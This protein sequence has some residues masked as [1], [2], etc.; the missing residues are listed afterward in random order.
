MCGSDPRRVRVLVVDDDD[1]ARLALRRMLEAAG[2]EVRE[3]ANGRIAMSVCRSDPP[4]VV[5][6]DIFMPEQEGIETIQSLRREF[7]GIKLIAI[8]GQPSASV[9]LRM[10]KL[11]GAQASLQKPVDMDTLV[12]TVRSVLE[13]PEPA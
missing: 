6:T 7:P 2:Y 1:E 13:G 12:A 4:D 9:Y 3:A 8:S 10:A 11:L 5:I